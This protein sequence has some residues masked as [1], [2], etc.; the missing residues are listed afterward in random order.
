M[1]KNRQAQQRSPEL[2]KLNNPPLNQ[3]G[4]R[5]IAPI[6][7]SPRLKNPKKQTLTERRR[8]V[9]PALHRPIPW[10]QLLAQLIMKRPLLLLLTFCG[11]MLIVAG[12]AAIGLT[13]PEQGENKL[14]PLLISVVGS[15]NSDTKNVTATDENLVSPTSTA[16]NSPVTI[17][18]GQSKPNVPLGLSVVIVAG[19][20]LGAW[21]L[22]RR[23]FQLVAKIQHQPLPKILPDTV[24]ENSPEKQ[25][26]GKPA[27]RTA[28]GSR[29]PLVANPAKIS[30]TDSI[31]R[32]SN[33][34]S[35]PRNSQ[36]V[37]KDTTAKRRKQSISSG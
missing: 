6:Q 4:R 5:P 25:K 14:K 36:K 21:L 32:W 22:Y 20:A 17:V 12:I 8:R 10:N 24:Q 29:K 15:V 16:E 7:L 2:P 35:L 33:G 18:T 28:P 30:V 26:N 37:L 19:C 11:G 34:Q 1:A 3:Q 27:R 31:M 13:R 23:R 9:N